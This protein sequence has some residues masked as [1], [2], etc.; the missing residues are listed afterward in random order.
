MKT[1]VIAEK[2]SV[3]RDIARVLKCT[4]KGDGYLHGGNYI[5]SWAI[6]H[7]VSLNDPEDYNPGLKR[8]NKG[9][10][11][12]LPQ[13][14]GLKP[15]QKTQAQLKILKKLMNA[16]DTREII[17]ATDSGREG[18][19]IFRYI[20][21]WAKCTKPVK[22]LWISSL[23]DAAINDGLNKM[24]DGQDYD[25]LYASAR[26][27]AEADWLVG[28][29]ATRAFTLKNGELLPVGRVQTPTLAMLVNRKK[30]I[31]AFVPKDYWEV[32]ATFSLSY[33]GLWISAEGEQKIDTK[34]K[35]DAIAAKVLYQEGNIDSVITEEKRQLPPQ[36]FDLT[37]LQRECNRRLGF[38]ASKTLTIAQ[39]LYE[40]H[41][42]ITYPRTD[43]RYLS[44]DIEP[45]LVPTLQSIQD[46]PYTNLAA[47]LISM[48]KLPITTRIVNDA[49]VTDHHAIIPTG[50]KKPIDSLTEDERAVYDRILRNFLA[51][52]YPAHVYDVTSVIT[53]VMKE[54]F[55]SKGRVD[56]DLGWTVIY[57]HE[58][59]SDDGDT[60][61][62]QLSRGT[63]TNT[64]KAEVLAKKTQ[65]PKPYTE[66]TL[67]SAME[68]AG[69]FVEDEALKEALKASGLGTPATRAA[70][71]EKLISSG[72]V[73]RNKKAL[74][75]TDKAVGL[76]EM[77]PPELTSPETTGKWERGLKRIAQGELDEDR[78]MDSIKRYVLYLVKWGDKA[79]TKSSETAGTA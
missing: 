74:A 61:L 24:K 40:K 18:E 56:K 8:W 67:L 44:K 66:A 55:L 41:K 7:L 29:N 16:R 36:L 31:D 9:D 73:I 77:S 51:A 50:A 72:Y 59:K 19:L 63:K 65:P 76:I 14:M 49:K 26:C 38:A 13:E 15:I 48:S 46:A 62:P 69:R 39:A 42:L 64:D 52:F 3:G 2:P 54:R 53:S 10:L 78:F 68:N 30:E 34:G 70:I 60:P 28:M 45:K 22:R 4:V 32:E 5:V 20:Y 11:P 21:K 25:K 1:L 43:S 33:T 35:A 79:E 57:T 75:P 47:P 6:G 71:I 17:C 37:E 27:R 23:T 12:I 58:K